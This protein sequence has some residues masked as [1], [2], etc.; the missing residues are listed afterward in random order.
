MP[1][2]HSAMLP[3]FQQDMPEMAHSG[4]ITTTGKWCGTTYYSEYSMVAK[5]IQRPAMHIDF[6]IADMT[7]T[8]SPPRHKL[9]IPSRMAQHPLSSIDLTTETDNKYRRLITSPFINDEVNR[10]TEDLLDKSKWAKTI[11]LICLQSLIMQATTITI[12]RT[13]VCHGN[14]RYIRTT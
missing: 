9:H 11:S 2:P 13:G 8:S 6:R 12:E 3:S 4:S 14:A 7:W 1:L 10:V 5:P